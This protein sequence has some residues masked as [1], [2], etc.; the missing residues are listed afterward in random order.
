MHGSEPDC[1]LRVAQPQSG[2]N[3]DAV[4]EAKPVQVRQ[5]P[6][7]GAELAIEAALTIRMVFHLSL[8]QTEG[9]LRSLADLIEVDLPI[10]PNQGAQ[11]SSSRSPGRRARFS[12][13]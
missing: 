5:I 8:R 7:S 3:T 2:A 9:F 13:R 4:A 10:P 1:M 6:L 11:P 12:T